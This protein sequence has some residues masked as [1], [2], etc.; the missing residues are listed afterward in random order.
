MSVEIEA[1]MRLHDAVEMERLLEQ[2]G[3]TFVA[4]LLET[5]TYF[6]TPTGRLKSTDQGLR[7]RVERSDS[8]PTRAVI[9]HK[10]PRAHGQL[11]SRSET[12]TGVEDARTAANLLAAL[13]FNP[14]LTFEKRRRRWRL[15]D[16]V[17]ELDNVPHI[18][19]FIEIDGP[20]DAAVMAARERLGLASEP[21]VK[22]SYIAMLKTYVNEHGIGASVIQFEPDTCN[23]A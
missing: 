14:V 10:G 13:G 21:I 18:G 22:A 12:E 17:I 11:K 1:K 5:N 15:G 2:L 4:E 8:R 6:D 23:A 3:A 9:T 16:C 19:S 20:T 7:I